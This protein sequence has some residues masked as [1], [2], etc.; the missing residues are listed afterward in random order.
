M[1]RGKDWKL[2]LIARRR[3]KSCN[4]VPEKEMKASKN[5]KKVQKEE[6]GTIKTSSDCSTTTTNKI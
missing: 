2:G 4:W 6:T 1:Y 3:E 5:L